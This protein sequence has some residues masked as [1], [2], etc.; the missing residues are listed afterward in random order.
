MRKLSALIGVLV[1]VGITAAVAA[2]DTSVGDNQKLRYEGGGTHAWVNHSDSPNDSNN[3]A[4]HITATVT[5]AANP[6]GCDPCDY[7]AA[8]SR[9][10]LNI[11][12]PAGDVKNL[13]F[14]FDESSHVGAGAPRISVQFQNGDV[15]YLSAFYC[16]QP[17]AVTGGAWGR[18]DFTG[19]KT[20]CGFYVTGDTGGFYA[21]DGTNSAWKVY[22]TAHPDQVVESAYLVADET[23]DYYIDRLSLGAGKMYTQSNTTAKSCTGEASC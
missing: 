21:A 1:I 20:D 16:N 23:G 5:P 15:A 4:L 6:E 3:K 2:A 8:Y 11:R 22:V 13:S 18:A 7:V 9:R 17:L 14:E 12:K 19:D 10:S